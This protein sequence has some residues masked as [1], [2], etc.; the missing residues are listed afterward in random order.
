MRV[1]IRY[2]E[3][4]SLP[5][6]QWVVGMK[7]TSFIT[8]SALFAALALSATPVAAQSRGHGNSRG[9]GSRG[10]AVVGHAVPRVGPAPRMISPRV[11]GRVPYRPYYYSYRPGL[12]IGLYAG[13]GYPYGY[14]GYPYSYGYPYGYSS[15]GYSSYGYSPY[16]YSSYG[17]SSYGYGYGGYYPPPPAGYLSAT[18][19]RAYGGVRIQSQ[20]RD[21]QIFA[22]GYYVGIVDDF[23][24]TFQHLNLEA[25]AHHIEIRLPDPNAPP[26]A[27]DVNV[28]PGQTVTYRADIR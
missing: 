6:V 22:D 1:G 16:G 13:Y 23:D 5:A 9:G 17:N 10:G 28:Q 7:H 4:A 25:G 20:H 24:G 18:P 8:A 27:F 21:A 15:Y 14:Y 3:S 26:I 12:R 19:G 2:T 11:V